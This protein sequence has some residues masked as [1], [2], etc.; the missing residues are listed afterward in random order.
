M[1][2]TIF[3]FFLFALG[4]NAQTTDFDKILDNIKSEYTQNP[5]KK[6][7]DD[8]RKN[9][10]VDGSF[11]GIDYTI[12]DKD[13]RSHLSKMSQL[14]QAY[15]NPNNTYYKDQTVYN[16]YIKAITF[17]INENHTPSNW[18]YRHIAYP[19]EMNKGLVFLI[20]EIKTKN[21]SLYRNI[22]TYQ[23]WAYLQKDHMEGAN[24]A[25]KI[26]GAFVAAVAEKDTNLLKEFSDL[27][28]VLTSVQD[29]GEGIEKDFGFYSHSG[30]GRQ[31]YTFGYGK[32]YL[33][34][35]LDYFLFTKGTQYNVQTL[36]NLE[37]MI[38]D[39]AQ[40]LFHEGNYDPNP[41]GRYNNTF[42]YMNEL[43][44]IVTKMVSLNTVNKSALQE[45]Y[46]RIS[47]QKKDLEGNKMFWRGDYMAHKRTNFL[48]TVRMTSTRTVGAEA[49]NGSGNYNYYAGAGV[50]YTIHTGNE[51]NGTYFSKF[52]S[53]QFPG[54]TVEQNAVT[55]P[56]PNWG[57]DGKNNNDF[58]GGVS[59]GTNGASA[60]IYDKQ[61]ITANKSWFF[62]GNVVL[63]LG[64]EISQ[65]NGTSDVYT[66]LNQT[67][68]EASKV[69]Y[70]QNNNRFQINANMNMVNNANTVVLSSGIGYVPFDS[71]SY[72][73]STQ[74]DLFKMY[75]NHG[76]NPTKSS[77]AYLLMPNVTDA[78][79]LNEVTKAKNNLRIEAQNESCHAVYDSVT[80]QYYIAFFKP[81]TLNL[82]TGL[83]VKVDN[84][85][86]IIINNNNSKF[87]VSNP[88]GEKANFQNIR[89][90]IT[91][92]SRSLF[93][94]SIQIIKTN[95]SGKTFEYSYSTLGVIQA[96]LDNGLSSEENVN[97]AR[98]EGKL[99]IE[100][101]EEIKNIE[102]YD[103]NGRLIFIKK[104]I[105][106][107]QVSI[108][109]T[110][111]E[112]ILILKINENKTIKIF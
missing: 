54:T 9:L 87:Y 81:Y 101:K 8:I 108:D 29:G 25:D 98:L 30:N 90:S 45:A 62:I 88:Y 100:S 83:V 49:G 18:W 42:E 31:I 55:L 17:W 58:A 7:I 2:Q 104:N 37:K 50:N 92:N 71:N 103:I 106:D 70:F 86:M 56:V 19:K 105:N 66:T 12:K 4:I 11:N 51:Y 43:K 23:E 79:I 57:K 72:T 52:N 40:Y 3:L 41:T 16:D 48:S 1:K 76:V 26:I 78:T 38:I 15:S 53:K 47:G 99:K 27:M 73:V 21:P 59:D 22:I 107:R 84:P 61:G 75:I 110:G 89:L 74:N 36:V 64:S 35:V 95:E 68:L 14:A 94:N 102:L 28:K 24:G 33:K 6:S 85:C 97:I 91:K 112:G 5:N 46:D 34:S 111:K 10:K 77:Y 63:A 96:R 67:N 39:H 32:E 80:S 65:N 13:L 93:D 69:S 82:S 20:E 109:V 44:N 60:M